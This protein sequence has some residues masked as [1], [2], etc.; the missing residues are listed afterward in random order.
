MDQETQRF[1]ASTRVAADIGGGQLLPDLRR[2]RGLGALAGRLRPPPQRPPGITDAGLEPPAAGGVAGYV[3]G[4][5]PTPAT[6]LWSACLTL[7]LRIFEA[8]ALDIADLARSTPP[9]LRVLGKGH[10]IVLVPPRPGGG[11]SGGP[12]H[13]RPHDGCTM[14][15]TR[16]DASTA[17]PRPDGSS[18]R[19]PTHASGYPGC[20]RTCC[21]TPTSPPCSTRRGPARRPDAAR[22]VADPRT[23]MPLRPPAPPW[24]ATPTTTTP[25]TWPPAPDPLQRFW[26]RARCR[27]TTE[28]A[29]RATTAH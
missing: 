5:R 27:R 25:P 15:N 2:R 26:R 10:K 6:S 20:T 16:A 17:T 8:C 11:A 18:T 29:S 3:A 22:H 19:P 14:L 12:R 9:R 7:G 21:A 13:R 1:A 24:T 28:N 23:T 4:P